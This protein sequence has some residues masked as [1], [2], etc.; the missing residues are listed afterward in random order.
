MFLKSVIISF[1]LGFLLSYK[2]SKNASH[3]GLNQEV[4]FATYGIATFSNDGFWKFDS[5][6]EAR[7]RK[8]EE[9]SNYRFSG[10]WW[11]K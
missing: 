5:F 11:V 3:S 4:V 1:I 9:I 8:S 2:Y 10:G 7:S 6:V